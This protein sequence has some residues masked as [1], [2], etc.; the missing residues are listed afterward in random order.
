MS[1]T[2]HLLI[3]DDEADIIDAIQQSLQNF[4]VEIE[5]T[6][7]PTEAVKLASNRPFDIVI[8][9]LKMK[10]LSGIELIKTIK[11]Q[12]PHT[13]FVI[14][15]GYASYDSALEALKLGVYDYLEKPFSPEEIRL[16]I[17]NLLHMLSLSQENKRLR[18]LISRQADEKHFVGQSAAY[19]HI[20]S[21]IEKVAGTDTTILLTGESG[22]GKE[23]VAREI[24]RLSPRHLQPFVVCNCAALPE[25]LIE[26]ELFGSEA[27][28]FTGARKSRRGSFELANGGTIFLDEIGEMPLAL[29]ARLLRVL[30]NRE[31]KRLGSEKTQQIDVRII[32]ATNRNL[33]ELV[34]QGRF[35]ED[36]F[37][38]LNVFTIH[39][40][41]LRERKADIPLLVETFIQ[42]LS[43]KMGK[44]IQG[45]DP[46]ALELLMN[47]DWKGNI[48]ELKNSIER[49]MILAEAP[50]LKMEDFLF[51]NA[52]THRPASN[53]QLETYLQN[54]PLVPLEQL[55]EAY[56]RYVLKQKHNNQT[57]TAKVLGISPAT[58]WR[59]LK[60]TNESE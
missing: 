1:K 42:Q 20:K 32:A 15:T 47:H 9:D 35:R 39:L 19:Q 10:P 22:T 38:R 56:I 18:H 25:T 21:M 34:R 57:Q 5:F 49:A 24:H 31:I 7:S 30:E 28:A 14:I 37:Y 26:S 4:P 44:P 51:L 27:G 55:T 11:Q 59:H 33:E 43:V 3:V 60:Q 36:L 46:Q 13:E 40:P 29:Q 58:L 50:I 48:R 41:P 6:Q 54:F 8:T 16:V 45:I 17:K 23:V 2:T 53:D 12:S 52:N